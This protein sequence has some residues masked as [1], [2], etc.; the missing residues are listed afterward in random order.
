MKKVS[1][2]ATMA[3]MSHLVVYGQ[4]ET[5]INPSMVT[6]SNNLIKPKKEVQA[7]SYRLGNL[8]LCTIAP[9]E[10]ETIYRIQFTVLEGFYNDFNQFAAERAYG[11]VFPEYVLNKNLT[12]YLIGDF[13]EL[14][15][16]KEVHHKIVDL[17]YSH[18]FV[19][20]YKNGMRQE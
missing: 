20:K 6:G 14:Y 12:R 19:V 3:I 16:A 10:E 18:A 8:D 15:D 11:D 5:K 17:G 7:F 9:I 2:I 13:T 1:F 4:M